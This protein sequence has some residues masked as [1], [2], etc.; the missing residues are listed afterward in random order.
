MPVLADPTKAIGRSI[1]TTGLYDL[2]VSEAL[3]RLV[4]EGNT[5]I[6]A[7][8]NVGY[9]TLL[10]SVGAGPRGRV[11]S[12]EPHPDL[13]GVLEENVAAAGRRF[14]V[15]RME[16]HNVALGER[17]GAAELL[18]PADFSTN[19]GVSRIADGPSAGR[20][21][22][23][24]TVETLDMLLG[25]ASAAVLKLDVE[26]FEIHVLRGAA[27][28]LESRRIHHIV[29]EDHDVGNS[30]VVRL[31][32][33]FGYRVFSLGWTMKGLAVSPVERGSLATTYEAPNYVATVEPDRVI[34]RCA[35][36]GFRVLRN[37]AG[38]S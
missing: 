10:A 3:V 34:A 9:M 37:L 13:F 4:D 33:S 28:A 32:Q 5:V 29:F 16:P 26:G 25:G 36:R 31:L 12:F 24:V 1:R 15:A 7:G 6:D 23:A 20:A 17:A 30:E 8:A 14:R 18:L 19:D 21:S 27:R 38:H 22:V 35:P 2:A 11:M